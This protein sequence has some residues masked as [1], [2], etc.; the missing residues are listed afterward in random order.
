MTHRFMGRLACAA[1]VG[2]VCISW[3]IAADLALVVVCRGLQVL[4]ILLRLRF[5]LVLGL[6][7]IKRW[8]VMTLLLRRR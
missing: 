4:R 5:T 6:L 8:E 7:I 2:L 3:Q 1:P